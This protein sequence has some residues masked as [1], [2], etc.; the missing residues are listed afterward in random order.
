MQVRLVSP[1]MP[2][3]SPIGLEMDLKTDE[4]QIGLILKSTMIEGRK[5]CANGRSSTEKHRRTQAVKRLTV[6]VAVELTG[7]EL[8]KHGKHVSHEGR[9]LLLCCC[10]CS[11]AVAGGRLYA[12]QLLVIFGRD[13]PVSPAGGNRSPAATPLWNCLSQKLTFKTK[14]DLLLAANSYELPK[15]TA[16]H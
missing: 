16:M 13:S 1:S 4:V 3:R 14:T 6:A 5:D 15:V 7:N 8:P 12:I 11:G 10:G 2:P 9:R